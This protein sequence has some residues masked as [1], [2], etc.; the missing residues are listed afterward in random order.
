MLHALMDGC[1]RHIALGGHV[2]EGDSCVARQNTQDLLIQIVYFI[3]F[4]YC[5]VIVVAI[6]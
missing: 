6:C 2:F 5:F 4:F 3:H 1:P